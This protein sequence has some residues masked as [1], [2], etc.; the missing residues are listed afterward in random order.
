MPF[1][2]R[3]LQDKCR[4]QRRPLFFLLSMTSKKAFDHVSTRW[5][6]NLLDKIGS[7][8]KLLS[9]NSYFH[10]S[11]KGTVNYDGATSVPFDIRNWL[12]HGCVLALTLFSIFFSMML[13]STEG[14]YLHTR[15]DGKLLTLAD[16]EPK[17][18]WAMSSSETFPYDAALVTRTMGDLQQRMERLSH[19]C[20]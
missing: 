18:K 4:Q 15:A 7:P 17:Q 13:S 11:M 12:K 9:V 6:F 1:S 5:L 16:W 8:S 20:N 14:V 3:H 10:N 2:V 19:A